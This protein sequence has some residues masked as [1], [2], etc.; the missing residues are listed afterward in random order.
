MAQTIITP[1]KDAVISEIE[2]AAP[3]E[4][5]FRA[6]TDHEQAG[7]WGTNAAYELVIWEMDARLGGK[8][9]SFSRQRSGADAGREF[10]HTGEILEIDPPRVLAYS[11]FANW[12]EDPSHRT[13]VRWELTPT[14]TGTHVKVTHNGLAQLPAACQGYSQG[15]PGLLLAVKNFVEK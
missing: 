11:W 15:W 8:W 6:L 1:D 13:V 3:P 9:R 10:D 7:Q 2:I 5:I 4:R 12:H 14:R